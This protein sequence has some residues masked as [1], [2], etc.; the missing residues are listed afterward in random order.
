MTPFGDAEKGAKILQTDLAQQQEDR[1]FSVPLENFADNLSRLAIIDKLGEDE[2]PT[3]FAAISGV[4]VSLQR[5]YQHER[6]ATDTIYDDIDMH[7]L[8][9]KSGRPSMHERRR[10]GLS[11][12][13]WTQRGCSTTSERS[14]KLSKVDYSTA[15]DETAKDYIRLSDDRDVYSLTIECEQL[16]PGM[17]PP[18]QISNEWISRGIE[19][20]ENDIPDFE[21][22]SG[23]TTNSTMIDWLDPLVDQAA[24]N[25]S[26]VNKDEV[27][28]IALTVRP[29]ARFV[30]RLEPPIAIPYHIATQLYASVQVNVTQVVFSA[31]ASM[32]DLIIP[33]IQSISLAADTKEMHQ[34]RKIGSIEADNAS[35]DFQLGL[36]WSNPELGVVVETLP[37]D[38]PRR[39]VEAL[40]VLRQYAFIARL[41]QN[42]FPRV[43][44]E[45]LTS[46]L[47]TKHE[48]RELRMKRYRDKFF[49]QDME[50]ELAEL[51]APRTT[52][53]RAL[54]VSLV[55]IPIPQMTLSLASKQ[56]L[57]KM[58]FN[59]LRNADLE[60]VSQNIVADDCDELI[61]QK[62][63]EAL[64][65]ALEMSEDLGVWAVWVRRKYL[66]DDE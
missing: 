54:D 48:T 26:H 52:S 28:S 31:S 41:L 30:A 18:I 32:A 66:H 60:I 40:P 6:Q 35:K 11:M 9:K 33:S 22:M 27:P 57:K 38:H 62:Q 65:M 56:G 12:D 53:V 13:Y 64:K 21:L 42:T 24:N 49:K 19:T 2:S 16:P 29:V 34:T 37:F 47:P 20:P 46:E 44:I 10:I 45:V 63:I 25:G 61:R 23:F 7:V 1:A 43:A 58:T 39:L 50:T 8:R 4:Y 14:S 51:L 17:Y 5:L 36:Y 55:T 3:C 15:T 59:I